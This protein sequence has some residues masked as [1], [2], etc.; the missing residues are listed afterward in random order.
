MTPPLLVLALAVITQWWDLAGIQTRLSAGLFASWQ[1]LGHGT[2]GLA[3]A[4][5]PV[6]TVLLLAA[7]G[8]T[9]FLMMRLRLY[10]AG[11]FVAAMLA[12]WFEASWA[13][14]VTRHWLVDAATPGLGLVL[15]FLAG[16]VAHAAEARARRTRLRIAFCDSLAPAT[17][18]KLV[19]RPE[20][21]NLEGETRNVTYLVCGVQRLAGLAADYR[22]DP[23][24]FTR[25]MNRVL[26]P[27]L[28]QARAHGGTIDRLT[29][30]GFAAF[31]NA[32]LADP[33]HALHACEAAHGMTAMAARMNEQVASGDK[34][35]APLA[36]GIGIA[37]GDMIAGGYG[38]LGYGV[39]GDAMVLA[40]RMQALSPQYGPAVIVSDETRRAAE[41]GFAFLEV[42]YIA[43][44]NADAPA[45]LYALLGSPVARASPK[46]RALST[47]HDHI[48]NSLRSQQWRE[49][50]ALIEQCRKL[51]GASQALYDLYLARIRYFESN[52]PGPNWDGAFRPILK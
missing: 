48:F 32:P 14:F 36:V 33:D 22:G 38:R 7:G 23:R 21:L 5:V 4:A 51:S 2:A 12:A 15:A 18:A 52:P 9:I 37:T 34:L 28:D 47:F 45:R 8:A 1:R 11:L 29:A 19:R 26:S 31:W 50:R 20:L 39:H 41:R 6:E 27:L 30:D 17:I 44:G 13:L 43:A 25:L 3:V 46:F 42:D 35:L 16:A 10:W 24:G 40:A 49:A